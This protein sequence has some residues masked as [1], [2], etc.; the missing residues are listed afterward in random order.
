[1]VSI[2]KVEP[3][4]L[5]PALAQAQEHEQ[6]SEVQYRDRQKAVVNISDLTCTVVQLAYSSFF[7]M[8]LESDS[9]WS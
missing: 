6:L 5:D 2:C 4:P 9:L 8:V 1:M 7:K 3:R